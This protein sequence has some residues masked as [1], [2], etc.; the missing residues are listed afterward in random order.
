MKTASLWIIVLCRSC[1]LVRLII[2]L[3]TV[4]TSELLISELG[5]KL[6]AILGYF[7]AIGAMLVRLGV[8]TRILTCTVV[9][10]P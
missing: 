6:W 9:A 7:K 1:S 5:I 10:Q 2:Y 8:V 3:A 4:I